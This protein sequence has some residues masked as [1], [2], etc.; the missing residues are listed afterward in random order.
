ML[1][2]VPSQQC[3]S[4]VHQRMA[5]IP[6]IIQLSPQPAAQHCS[7]GWVTQA[8]SLV[9]APHYQPLLNDSMLRPDWMTWTPHSQHQGRDQHFLDLPTEHNK[10]QHK[11]CPWPL[12]YN[13]QPYLWKI[14]STPI[15]HLRDNRYQSNGK[16]KPNCHTGDPQ[17]DTNTAYHSLTGGRVPAALSPHNL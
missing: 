5:Q 7:P 11:A 13:T 1:F 6:I 12:T 15:T 9:L 10:Q 3:P 14:T 2:L 4:P 8:Y 16:C 17:N